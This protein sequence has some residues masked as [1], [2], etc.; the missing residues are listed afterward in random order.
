MFT[1]LVQAVGRV[2]EVRPRGDLEMAGGASGA[3]I[4]IDTGGWEYQARRGDSVAVNGCC[5]TVAEVDERI[6]EFD[7]VAETLAKTTLG[8][9][10]SGSEAGTRVNL[11]RSLAAGDLM[12]GH[13]VQ[14][15][16]E[17]IGE[18]VRVQAGPDYR[19]TIRPPRELMAAIVPKG[20]VTVD[21]VSLTVARVGGSR[22]GEEPQRGHLDSF[23]VALIPT[24]LEMTTLGMLREG[25]KVNIETDVVARAVVHWLEHYRRN[26]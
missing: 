1:G 25:S 10:G 11:E 19:L 4:V 17:G 6:L 26:E 15:H 22:G 18:V 9:F 3:R 23:A 5:L 13:V 12:G 14:G 24:T 16:V 21:G 20:S 7:A 2:M 8:L